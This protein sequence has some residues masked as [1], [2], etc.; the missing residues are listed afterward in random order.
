MFF[1]IYLKIILEEKN[2]EEPEFLNSLQNYIDYF[3]SNQQEKNEFSKPILSENRPK[4]IID[5]KN[6]NQM[7][8]QQ[9]E[10]YEYKFKE[11]SSTKKNRINEINSYKKRDE[12]NQNV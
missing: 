4:E 10:K 7:L 11:I 1:L 12:E 9:L 6:E 8:R 5:L 2:A 3:N